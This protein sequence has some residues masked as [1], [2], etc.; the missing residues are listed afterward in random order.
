MIRQTA[1]NQDGRTQTI[2]SPSQDAQE[3]LIRACYKSVGL[4]P[5]DTVYVEAHG[6]GTPAGDPIEAAAIGTVFGEGR[7]IDK[8]LLIGSVKTN[9]GHMES[10]SGFS[11]ILKV[12][13][14]LEKG[15]IPPHINFDKPNPDIDFSNLKLKASPPHR[16]LKLIKD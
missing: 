7:S 10:V 16:F 14:S 4:S 5:A 2:T 6:T 12:A 3:D 11:A 9:V 13:M 15:M 8:T 1:L